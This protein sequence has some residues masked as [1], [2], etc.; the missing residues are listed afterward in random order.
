VSARSHAL[1]LVGRA[2]GF[3]RRVGLGPAVERAGG[4]AARVVVREREVDGLRLT[5][6]HLGHL[7]YLAELAD[8]TRE[9]VLLD[10]LRR[11]TRP[12]STLLEAGAHIGFLTLQAARSVGPEGRVVA[13]E[14]NPDTL[15]TLHRNLRANELAERVEVVPSALGAEPGRSRFVLRGGGGESGLFGEGGREVEVDV[16]T[17][18]DWLGARSGLPPLSVVKVDVEGAEVAVLRGAARTLEGSDGVTLL[19]ECNPEALA[20]AASSA[21]ELVGVVRSL[22]FAVAWADERE[23]RLAAW[24]DVRFDGGYVNLVCRRPTP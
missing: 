7:H 10:E 21:D 9:Q 8:G 19:V 3:L 6:T 2:G 12:G 4:L 14:A 11:A 13:F 22:G 24:E 15:P 16:T 18:D 1:S 23:R 17:V 5:G 20:A